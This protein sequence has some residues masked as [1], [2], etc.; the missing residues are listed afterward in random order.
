M[1]NLR[2]QIHPNP[3][4]RQVDVSVASHWSVR[5]RLPRRR[6]PLKKG[7][8]RCEI[9]LVLAAR[10]QQV[11]PI[12]PPVVGARRL[13][14]HENI[15]ALGLGDLAASLLICRFLEPTHQRRTERC[16][17]RETIHNGRLEF[18]E[19]KERSRYR[20]KGW[21]NAKIDRAMTS[22][23]L[24]LIAARLQGCM[25]KAR[26]DSLARAGRTT[27][28]AARNRSDDSIR[29]RTLYERCGASHGPP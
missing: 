25:C 12:D 26:D 17:Q 27:P 7:L 1:Y 29:I 4:R 21:S 3:T 14:R 24:A 22:N 9:A 20:A 13:W 11:R 18:D 5:R 2:F 8:S 16:H 6:T 19:E 28:T 23:F 15:G 10:P